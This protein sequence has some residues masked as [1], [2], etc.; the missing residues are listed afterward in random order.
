MLG[1][2]PSTEEPSMSISDRLARGLAAVTCAALWIV[3]G[4]GPAPAPTAKT[5]PA[6]D[7]DH[8]DH[9]DH[10]HHHDH[11]HASPATLAEGVAALEK[12]AATVKDRLAADARDEADEAVHGLGHLLEDLQ[13]L[14]RKSDLADDAKRAATEA[15][16]ELF[17][18]FDTLDT[19]LH[20]GADSETPPADVHTSVA[21]RIKDAIAA[22]RAAVA[23]KSADDDAAA[24]IRDASKNEEDR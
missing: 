11:D 9:A 20:G 18:A 8:D 7:H 13:G 15:L 1:S 21:P 17:N 16:D 4:C 19:A 10:D 6:A 24:I 2:S 3:T 22:L 12:A 5:G 14:V 23:P